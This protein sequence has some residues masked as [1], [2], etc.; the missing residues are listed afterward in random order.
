MNFTTDGHHP[1]AGSTD[2]SA[3]VYCLYFNEYAPSIITRYKFAMRLA[4]CSALRQ[5]IEKAAQFELDLTGALMASDAFFPFN[6]CVKMGTGQ[7]LLLLCSP[8]GQ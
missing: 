8:V 3:I 7:A 1:F 4:Q 5:A 2:I 6:D